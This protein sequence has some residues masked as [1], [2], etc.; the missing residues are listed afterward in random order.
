ML[1]II[2]M[3]MVQN[4]CMSKMFDAVVIYIKQKLC[5]GVTKLLTQLSVDEILHT[6]AGSY[7]FTDPFILEVSQHTTFPLQGVKLW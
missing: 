5:T 1:E 3:I 7:F 6:K 2:H 4:V